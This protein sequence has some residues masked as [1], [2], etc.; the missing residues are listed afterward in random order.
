[1]TTLK[2]PIFKQLHLQLHIHHDKPKLITINEL[3]I[4]NNSFKSEWS[5]HEILNNKLFLGDEYSA[6]NFTQITQKNIKCI[7]CLQTYLNNDLKKRYIDENILFYFYNIKDNSDEDIL[8]YIDD[9]IKIIDNV[10]NNNQAVLIHCNKGI[11]RSSSIIIAYIM[12]KYKKS[13]NDAFEFVMQKKN[14][15]N[16]NLGFIMQLEQYDKYINK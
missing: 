9:I 5:A 11:S 16:P 12:K 7:I 1:M 3:N 15:I 13:F 8:K 2:K 10:N 4:L 14:N 6:T